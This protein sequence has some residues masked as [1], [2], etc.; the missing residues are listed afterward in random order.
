MFFYVL[1]GFMCYIQFHVFVP[2]YYSLVLI[3][4]KYLGSA[5]LTIC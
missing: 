3:N 1:L 2:I 4:T 5:L